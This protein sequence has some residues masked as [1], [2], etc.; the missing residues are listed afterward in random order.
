[1]KY[2]LYIS[3][4]NYCNEFYNLFRLIKYTFT[5]YVYNDNNELIFLEDLDELEDIGYINERRRL[6]HFKTKI[7]V[8]IHKKFDIVPRERKSIH[9]FNDI[10]KFNKIFN[11]MLDVVR[12]N[13][14]MLLE[15][16]QRVKEK[17]YSILREG[18]KNES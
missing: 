1:M 16:R 6:L 7:Q 11:E 13:S 3:N 18:M 5:V 12:L 17:L 15:D 2:N 14:H 8:K 10:K 9:I 4:D